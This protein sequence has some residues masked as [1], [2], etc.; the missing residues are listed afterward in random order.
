MEITIH[1]RQFEVTETH[2][3]FWESVE[4]GKWEPYTFDI[5]DKYVP[6][7]DNYLDI[8]AWIGPTVLYASRFG[9]RCI[10]VEPDPVACEQL[11]DNNILNGDE[12]EVHNQA[13]ADHDG[14]LV[15]GS[16]SLGNSM[17]RL[18]AAHPGMSVISVYCQTLDS[19]VRHGEIEGSMFI[20]M[21]VEGS[22]ELILRDIEFFKKHKPTLYLSLHPGWFRNAS[23]ARYTIAAVSDLYRFRV[24]PEPTDPNTILFTDMDG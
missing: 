17:T 6:L 1:G 10:A 21:D 5:L 15:L 16:E 20:K 2:K 22:E 19:F 24:Y 12:F 18:E 4:A 8:G 7:H 14:E 13:I 3:A 9:T 11:S 23:L